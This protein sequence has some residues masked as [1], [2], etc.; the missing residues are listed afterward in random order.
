MA[1]VATYCAAGGLHME[2]SSAAAGDVIGRS[3]AYSSQCG[4]QCGPLALK[5]ASCCTQGKA[6][7]PAGTGC[8]QQWLPHIVPQAA[9]TWNAA[10]LQLVTLS[11]GV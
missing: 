1:V 7:G 6:S 8:V 2:C 5:A 3:V 9:C 11:A 10:V 4:P